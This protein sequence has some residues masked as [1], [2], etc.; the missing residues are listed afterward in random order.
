MARRPRDAH[1]R[2]V[3]AIRVLLDDIPPLLRGIIVDALADRAEVELLA[4][5]SFVRSPGEHIDVILVGVT[6][7]TDLRR[8]ECLLSEWPRARVLLVARSGRHAV[9]YELY[10]HSTVL[11]DLSPST[12]VTAICHGSLTQPA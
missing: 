9:M 2:R 4:A 12:L 1:I 5:E 11:G 6:D 8:A 7:P 3:S 10:P